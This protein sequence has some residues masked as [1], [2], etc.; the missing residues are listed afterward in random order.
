MSS[1]RGEESQRK[2]RKEGKNKRKE[3]EKRG[4]GEESQKEG[5]KV[6]GE[7][8]S[9]KGGVLGVEWPPE[10]MMIVGKSRLLYLEKKVSQKE[11]K[12]E[13]DK[14]ERKREGER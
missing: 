9:E 3:G 14:G 12:E 7:R 11:S 6:G 8:K 4:R 1:S 10:E 5:R 13:G 2:D